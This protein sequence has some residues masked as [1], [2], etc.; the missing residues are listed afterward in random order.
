MRMAG[1]LEG[2]RVASLFT[3]G[4]E[5]VELT[6]PLEAVRDAGG[7]PALISLQTGAVQMFNHLDKGETIEAE[8][9]HRPDERW[10][11]VGRRGGRR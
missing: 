4:V 2:K 7:T 11:D 1:Q 6:K 3:Q 5:Q 8:P 10:C 9:P